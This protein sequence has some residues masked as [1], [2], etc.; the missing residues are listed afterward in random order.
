MPKLTMNSNVFCPILSAWVAIS[1]LPCKAPFDSMS[2]NSD[3]SFNPTFS[4][5]L[6]IQGGKAVTICWK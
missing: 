1:W 5:K 2:F 3:A 6:L 4:R